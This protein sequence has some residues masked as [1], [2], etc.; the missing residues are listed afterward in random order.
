MWESS[1]CGVGLCERIQ[2]S[3]LGTSKQKILTK[4]WIVYSVW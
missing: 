1:L 3:V 2:N 4:K